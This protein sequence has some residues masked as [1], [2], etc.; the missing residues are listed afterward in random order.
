M[1]GTCRQRSSLFGLDDQNKLHLQMP[2]TDC[3]RSPPN[4][5][6]SFSATALGIPE[7]PRS[8]KKIGICL[9]S[10]QNTREHPIDAQVRRNPPCHCSPPHPLGGRSGPFAHLP[11]RSPERIDSQICWRSHLLEMTR[12]RLRGA[13]KKL[14]GGIA[15]RFKPNSLTDPTILD[16]DH[17]TSRVPRGPLLVVRDPTPIRSILPNMADQEEDYSS[18]PLTDRWVH[19]VRLARHDVVLR[20]KQI[21]VWCT[22]HMSLR[23]RYGKFANKP[24]K[25]Q[26]NNSNSPP[27]SMTLFSS[28]SSRI[29]R[30]GRVPWRT[31]TSLLNKMA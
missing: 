22:N 13:L 14:T 19:K 28:L 3:L 8:L 29:L 2:T 21:C 23:V 15:R 25:M 20:V 1:V 5:A 4:K 18:L 9:A 16:E 30:Y 31:A 10:E 11:L 12:S 6:H 26:R 17:A 7:G 24:T 27:M